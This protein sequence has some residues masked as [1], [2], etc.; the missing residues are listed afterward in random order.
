MRSHTDVDQLEK[1]M[2]DAKGQLTAVLD[3]DNR[4]VET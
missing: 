1:P 4:P 3:A 2:S